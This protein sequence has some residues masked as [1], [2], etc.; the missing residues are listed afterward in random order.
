M[1]YEEATP[2]ARRLVG[3]SRDGVGVSDDA[4]SRAFFYVAQFLRLLP[5]PRRWLYGT[6]GP[7]ASA[8]LLGDQLN[9]VELTLAPPENKSPYPKIHLKLEPYPLVPSDQWH[10]ALSA[11]HSE[12]VPHGPGFNT[13]WRFVPAIGT[14]PLEI[15]GQVTCSDRELYW[16]D[17][18]ETF[19]RDVA[20]RVGWKL[21]D[22]T[23]GEQA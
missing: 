19:A 6:S 14:E 3:A 9:V 12:E 2:V 23:E 17:E 13:Q 7:V 11:W 1:T 16:I 8:Q 10:A 22:V 18:N 20:R 21:E 4:A 15:R 5:L